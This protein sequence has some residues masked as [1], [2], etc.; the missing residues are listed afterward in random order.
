MSV[1]L[2]PD[3]LS[4]TEAYIAALLPNQ[5]RRAAFP[6]YQIPSTCIRRKTNRSKFLCGFRGRGRTKEHTRRGLVL[7]AGASQIQPSANSFAN[8]HFHNP[9]NH[10]RNPEDY[11][12][13][14]EYDSED[15]QGQHCAGSF[16][17]SSQLRTV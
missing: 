7:L 10:R 2:P 8:G 9:D 12:Q 5:V 15:F 3:A 4:R 17:A 16:W 14:A 13:Q 1:I 11:E 6:R